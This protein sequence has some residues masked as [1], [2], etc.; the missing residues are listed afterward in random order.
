MKLFPNIPRRKTRPCQRKKAP[1]TVFLGPFND[2]GGPPGEG[3]EAVLEAAPV[4]QP[5]RVHIRLDS[6]HEGRGAGGRV[7]DLGVQSVRLKK[8][9]G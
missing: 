5:H 4:V 1:L 3:G 7:S 6:A 9:E 8:R 2:R